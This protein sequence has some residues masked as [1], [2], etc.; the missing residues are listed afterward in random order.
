MI[1]SNPSSVNDE[2]LEWARGAITAWKS[3]VTLE[4]VGLDKITQL[5]DFLTSCEPVV[6]AVSEIQMSRESDIIFRELT[7]NLCYIMIPKEASVPD[8]ESAKA[9]FDMTKER[10]QNFGPSEDDQDKKETGLR[11][12]KSMMMAVGLERAMRYVR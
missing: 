2:L 4:L 10:V 8:D 6:A 12:T 9:W 5:L 7:D 1:E 3:I 11:F